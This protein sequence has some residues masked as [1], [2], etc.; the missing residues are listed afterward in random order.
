MKQIC[1]KAVQ[2]LCRKPVVNDLDPSTDLALLDVA[3]SF[4]SKDHECI[5]TFSGGLHVRSLDVEDSIHVN[6]NRTVF[7]VDISVLE[8]ERASLS[9]NNLMEGDY[10]FESLRC[11]NCFLSYNLVPSTIRYS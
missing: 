2:L 7:G 9:Q 6:V 5:Q 4:C 8:D 1:F 11:V 10:S 3:N